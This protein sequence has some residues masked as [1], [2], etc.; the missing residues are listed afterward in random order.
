ML[1]WR[2]WEWSWLWEG[3]RGLTV[4]CWDGVSLWFLWKS[5]STYALLLLSLAS[6]ADR[7]FSKDRSYPWM[8][9][10]LGNHGMRTQHV[11][12]DT[13][14]SKAANGRLHTNFTFVPSPGRHVLWRPDH[15]FPIIVERTREKQALDMRSGVM[16]Y[17]SSCLFSVHELCFV[18]E[19]SCAEEQMAWKQHPLRIAGRYYSSYFAVSRAFIFALGSLSR[20]R[21]SA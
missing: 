18:G 3:A 8:L 13:A 21:P 16:W 12:V 5:Q 2:A 11:S 17:V 9:Q 6:S 7:S 4:W 1:A 20:C 14:F 15:L 19:R 10:W